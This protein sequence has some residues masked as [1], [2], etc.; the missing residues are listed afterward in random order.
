MNFS[1]GSA[2][3]IASA[4]WTNATRTLTGLG[5]GA[6]SFPAAT[7]SNIP[8]SG[9][10]TIRP[11]PTAG[12]LITVAVTAGIAGGLNVRLSDGT[13]SIQI[14]FVASGESFSMNLVVNNTCF[15]TLQNMDAV[16][17]AEYMFAAI[18][19]HQ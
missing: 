4:V 2:T 11:A 12:Y 19:L 6:L 10:V 1:G 8:P 15:L 16:N 17:T 18:Q 13:A 14:Q 3:G 5:G 7:F 9:T